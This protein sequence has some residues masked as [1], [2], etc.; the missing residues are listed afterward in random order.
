MKAE[1]HA[2]QAM[3]SRTPAPRQVAGRAENSG[4]YFGI[5]AVVYLG[6]LALAE[7]TTTFADPRV[8][9]VIHTIILAVILL[10]ASLDDEETPRGFLLALS[11]TPLIRILSLSLP[12]Q[13]VDLQY[14][15]AV[16]AV[17][18]LIATVVVARILGF[19]RFDLGLTLG[20]WRVQLLVGSSGFAFGA[21]EYVILRPEP[22]VDDFSWVAI[23]VPALILLVGTGFMEE[24]LFRGLMQSAAREA[25]GRSAVLYV[26]IVFAI[27]HIG[28]ESV[29]DVVFVFAVALFFGWVVLRTRSIFGVTLAH[30]ITNVALFLFMP[31]LL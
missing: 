22:L 1:S 2:V 9:M 16:V 7:L 11:L 31:F 19:S 17:P 23:L 3:P 27:L 26:A 24:L 12:L 30:G 10:Q 14:W 5:I 4:R 25:L 13:D 29:F 20:R 6:A 21:L 28:Y 18:L 8:G 15:Y